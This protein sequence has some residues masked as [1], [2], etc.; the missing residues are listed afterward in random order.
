MMA[1]IRALRDA[2][3]EIT[4]CTDSKS[5]DMFEVMRA[6][7]WVAR[8]QGGG[9]DI[10][11]ET[12][13][14]WATEGGA[15]ALGLAGKIGALQPGHQADI[16][17]LDAGVPS[18]API[19]DGIGVTVHA[20]SGNHIRHVLIGGRQ[21]LEDGRPTRVQPEAIIA[22]AQAVADRLWRGS[23]LYVPRVS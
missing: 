17:I 5:G 22:A 4:L 12:V 1:P 13:L 9:Y 6:A 15:R 2:G 21:V 14:G 23:A 20:G 3:A 19:V 18:L 16:L 10:N 7:L 11:A 8:V